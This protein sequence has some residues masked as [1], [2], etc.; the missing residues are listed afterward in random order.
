[1]SIPPRRAHVDSQ[2]VRQPRAGET[3]VS[4][5][6]FIK[7]LETCP[8]REKIL[9]L[10]SCHAAAGTDPKLEPSTAEQA[11]STKDKPTRPF[12]PTSW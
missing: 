5:K 3:G 12:P 1:M 8:S 6:A 11:E 9:L 7:Q 2:G 4:L 10:D